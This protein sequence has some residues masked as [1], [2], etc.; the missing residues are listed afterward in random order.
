RQQDENVA[1]WD[2]VRKGVL[3][4]RLAERFQA[5]YLNW[6]FYS[7]LDP[8]YEGYFVSPTIE[9]YRRVD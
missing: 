4:Y 7:R 2:T 1:M 9:I 8:M 3:P 6:R 5:R